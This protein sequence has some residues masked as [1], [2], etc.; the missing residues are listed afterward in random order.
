MK[1]NQ[2]ERYFLRPAAP[3]CNLTSEWPIF[4]GVLDSGA[5]HL[6]QTFDLHTLGET[7]ATTRCARKAPESR[8]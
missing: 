1:D 5:R 3:Y 8:E 7:I 2:P 6:P 4:N